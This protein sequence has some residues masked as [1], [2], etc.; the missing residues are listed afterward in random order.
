M[1][2]RSLSFISDLNY[3]KAEYRKQDFVIVYDFLLTILLATPAESSLLF[4]FNC[5]KCQYVNICLIVFILKK[6][7]CLLICI[8][9]KIGSLKLGELCQD[10]DLLYFLEKI[11]KDQNRTFQ[12]HGGY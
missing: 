8:N 4:H 1:Y 9:Q 5:D 6:T 12:Q 10:A 3:Q 11:V 2:L 7:A